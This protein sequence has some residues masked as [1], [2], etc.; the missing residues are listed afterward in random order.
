MRERALRSKTG[1]PAAA[2]PAALKWGD[3]EVLEKSLALLAPRAEELVAYFYADLF[4]R[5]PSLRKLFPGD[6]APQRDRLLAA[7]LAL[8]QTGPELAPVLEQLGRDHRKFG[9]Q[10]G[11]YTTVGESLIASLAHFAGAAWTPQVQ[12]AWL[13]RYL[14][15]VAV[16]KAAAAQ[17]DAPPFWYATVIDHVICGRDVAILR[18]RPHRPYPYKAGQY[19][20]I[21]SP[22]LPRVWRSYSI[23]NEPRPAQPLEFH[24]RAVGRRGLSDVLLQSQPG[25]TIR[26]GPPRGQV[27]LDGT[28]AGT[29]KLFVAGG[30]GWSTMKS[31][32]R[33]SQREAGPVVPARLLVSCRPGEPYDPDFHQL[34][35]S[36]PNL[37]TTLVH[38]AQD[39]GAE[40][41]SPQVH[42]TGL[43][44]FLSGPAEM[45]TSAV[46]L[47]T[48]AG[49]PRS[50]IHHDSLV[51]SA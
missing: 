38:S 23:A 45:L 17:D 25:D 14:A 12:Q 51:M 44:V 47:L 26:L 15:A 19:A 34:V 21:E 18:V 9:V 7:L 28:A 36:V 49:V 27:T 5:M 2:D 6:M 46:T 41:R 8:V 33:Q 24:V 13:E 39:L 16:M 35:R 50:R 42:P 10:S 31:L 37:S 4:R 29:P 11:Q 30:T 22:R 43:D 20:T 3:Q 32:L 48:S 40:L 1:F